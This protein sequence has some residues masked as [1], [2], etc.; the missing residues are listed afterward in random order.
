MSFIAYCNYKTTNTPEFDQ[1]PDSWSFRAL[2]HIVATP[3]TD[4][5]HETPEFLDEGVLFIS[6]EAVSKG[7]IN[8][9]KARFIA[10]DE[11]RR[12]SKI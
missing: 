12:Y 3:I 9:S 10:H 11:H 6:A 1:I 5:P 7:E 8:F 4:G 2:K